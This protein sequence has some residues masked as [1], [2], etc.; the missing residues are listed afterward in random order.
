MDAIIEKH[1]AKAIG[2]G[3]FSKLHE[4]ES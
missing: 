3:N 2:L 1:G 4:E